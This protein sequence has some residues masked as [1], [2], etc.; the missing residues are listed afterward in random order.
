METQTKPDLIKSNEKNTQFMAQQLRKPSGEFAQKVGEQMNKFNEV[1]YDFVFSLMQIEDYDHILEIGFGNGKFFN[2]L[3]TTA[4]LLSV[5][6]VDFSD[7]MIEEAELN[8]QS[9]ISTRALKL[10][11]RSSDNL[12]FPENVFDKVF[13]NMVIYFWD[14]P[15]NY[16]KEIRRVLKPDGKFYAGRKTA[17]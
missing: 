9:L 17:R 10:Y 4:K 16:L 6:G 14:N 15:E 3:F 11:N 2:K 13:C 5:K 1:L 8:N 12:P 7:E